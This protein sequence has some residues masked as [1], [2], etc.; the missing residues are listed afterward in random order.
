MYAL[1]QRDDG[2]KNLMAMLWCVGYGGTRSNHTLKI[3][4]V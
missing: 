2:D 4:P 3:D 1:G